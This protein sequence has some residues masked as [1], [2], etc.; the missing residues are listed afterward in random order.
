M[1]SSREPR[2]CERIGAK[3]TPSAWNLSMSCCGEGLLP[4]KGV[5]QLGARVLFRS[6]LARL[7]L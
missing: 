6:A 1:T 5:D 4:Q 7:L 2:G 3:V